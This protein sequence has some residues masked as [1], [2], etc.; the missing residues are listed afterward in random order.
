MQPSYWCG[1]KPVRSSRVG[2]D[3]CK[4]G[5]SEYLEDE[6]V[7]MT[8]GIQINGLTKKFNAKGSTKVDILLVEPADN[9]GSYCTSCGVIP[10]DAVLLTVH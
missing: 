8:A 1:T 9:V 7:D 5:K 3:D 10:S 4:T 2:G 6:P